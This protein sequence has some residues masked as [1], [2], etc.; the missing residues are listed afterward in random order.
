MSRRHGA[1]SRADGES[2]LGIAFDK[3]ILKDGGEMPLN[4]MIQAMAEPVDLFRRQT[5]PFGR[6]RDAGNDANFADGETRASA[7]RARKPPTGGVGSGKLDGG[8]LRAL[9]A[10]SRGVLACAD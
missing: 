5:E 9:D 7:E 8:D 6:H 2:A 3:A 1:R 10:K 4:V